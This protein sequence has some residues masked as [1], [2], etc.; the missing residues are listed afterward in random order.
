MREGKDE[1]DGEREGSTV[2]E[3]SEFNSTGDCCSELKLTFQ[4]PSAF[5]GLELDSVL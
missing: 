2:T 4:Q 3:L 5:S 1:S